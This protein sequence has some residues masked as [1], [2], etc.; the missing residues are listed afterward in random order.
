[1]IDQIRAI[2][3]RLLT[4]KVGELPLELQQKVKETIRIVLNLDFY[5][6]TPANTYN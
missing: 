1:M 6:S 2:D 5:N 3:N 4:S